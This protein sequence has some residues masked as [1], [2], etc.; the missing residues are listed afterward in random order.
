MP[1]IIIQN[2]KKTEELKVTFAISEQDHRDK[3]N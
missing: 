3:N 1:K 2:I